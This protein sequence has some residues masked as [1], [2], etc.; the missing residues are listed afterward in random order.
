[1]MWKIRRFLMYQNPESQ[2][3]DVARQPRPGRE[4]FEEFQTRERLQQG[5]FLAFEGVGGKDVYNI[6]APFTVDGRSYIAG[7]VEPRRDEG[8]SE[9]QFFKEEKGVWVPAAEAPV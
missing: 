4:L 7:R 6:T 2:M 9:V 1:M 3:Q 5:E 8:D